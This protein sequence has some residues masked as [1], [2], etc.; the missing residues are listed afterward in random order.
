LVPSLP[1]EGRMRLAFSPSRQQHRQQ[2]RLL[3]NLMWELD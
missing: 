1:R 3:W 2:K